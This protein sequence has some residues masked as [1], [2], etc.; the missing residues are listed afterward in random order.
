MLTDT[1]VEQIKR[2]TMIECVN[3]VVKA[4][5]QYAFDEIERISAFDD[6]GGEDDTNEYV[7]HAKSTAM[8]MQIHGTKLILE[9]LGMRLL[10]C[11]AYANRG[12]SNE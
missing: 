9:K 6:D 3:L 12:E 4:S 1:E 10:E 2:E 11:Q 8:D 7:I 5:Y